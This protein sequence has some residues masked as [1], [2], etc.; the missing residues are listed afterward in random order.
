[1]S[2]HQPVVEADFTAPLVRIELCGERNHEPGHD[3]VLGPLPRC[4]DDGGLVGRFLD[5]LREA[6]ISRA[7][8]GGMSGG[9]EYVG[10]F[11]ASDAQRIREWL[12]E[13]PQVEI[14]DKDPDAP[15]TECEFRRHLGHKSPLDLWHTAVNYKI[16]GVPTD[17][18][19][20]RAWRSR[21]RDST[22]KNKLIDQ[23]VE[24]EVAESGWGWFEGD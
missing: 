17:D 1:M 7:V 12:D 3:P 8:R 24:A 14:Y 22:E 19:E 10:Y 16:E 18:E 6:N 2:K 21:L 13:Q 9:G 15:L 5:F 11:T 23:I 4:P 20:A